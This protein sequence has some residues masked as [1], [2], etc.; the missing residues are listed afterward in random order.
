MATC[1]LPLRSV[2]Y[3]TLPPLNSLDGLGP[4]RGDGAG[5]GVGHPGRG[6]PT[7]FIDRPAASGPAWRSSRRVQHA[8][9]SIWAARSSAPNSAPA[10]SAA[11]RHL[12]L[13]EHGDTGRAAGADGG[14]TV[15]RIWSSLAGIRRA[16]R[17]TSSTDSSGWRW[18]RDFRRR[19]P[20]RRCGDASRS[21]R[22]AA[23]RVPWAMVRSFRFSLALWCPGGV[24]RVGFDSGQAMRHVGFDPTALC[25][26]RCR[27]RWAPGDLDTHG[28]A[29]P[30][31]CNG[32]DVVG[33]GSRGAGRSR[34]TGRR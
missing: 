31:I 22:G 2:R 18:P 4:G 14:A 23:S 21:K 11:I 10:T 28:R 34:S 1:T 17:T 33:V 30:A 9:P 29:V 7:P 5:L 6:G 25:G 27:G 12:A 26:S 16:G 32:V 8:P 19:S 3:S 15:P 20:H 24:S 13:S